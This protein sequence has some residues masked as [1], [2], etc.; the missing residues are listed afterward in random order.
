[1]SALFIEG[2]KDPFDIFDA[3]GI[4]PKP[5]YSQRDITTAWRTAF[6]KIHSDKRMVNNN[7]IPLFPTPGDLNRA[8][9]WLLESPENIQ[10]AYTALRYRHRST[11]NPHAP[12]GSLEVL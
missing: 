11:W 2:F 5:F 1:M 7:L 12:A 6:R 10:K 9:E 3:L 4:S 8:K